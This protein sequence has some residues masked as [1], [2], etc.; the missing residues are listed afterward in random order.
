MH[1]MGYFQVNDLKS[2]FSPNVG[3]LHSFLPSFWGETTCKT[4]AAGESSSRR[5]N[6]LTIPNLSKWHFAYKNQLPSCYLSSVGLFRL[7][8]AVEGGRTTVQQLTNLL[9]WWSL[10]VE[11]LRRLY[12]L[13]IAKGC[14]PRAS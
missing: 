9:N 3:N 1:K 12:L 14:A 5:D 10:I 7:N 4:F 13:G 2:L 8:I 6:N 11:R